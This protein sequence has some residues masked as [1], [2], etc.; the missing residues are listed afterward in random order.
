MYHC[1]ILRY[2]L[3]FNWQRVYFYAKPVVVHAWKNHHNHWFHII[4]V[5]CCHTFWH[6]GH[7]VCWPAVPAA[8]LIKTALC[9]HKKN[10]DETRQWQAHGI[11]SLWSGQFSHRRKEVSKWRPRQKEFGGLKMTHSFLGRHSFVQATPVATRL[12]IVS[13][14]QDPYPPF[15][16]SVQLFPVWNWLLSFWTYQSFV[17]WGQC[18]AKEP[19]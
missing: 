4:F 10:K 17:N 7:G 1:L 8:D 12:W 5:F 3:V 9:T 16:A 13:Q 2:G 18:C 11:K 6:C 19:F 14:E 15:P